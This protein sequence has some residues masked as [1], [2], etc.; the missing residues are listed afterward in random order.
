V[1]V[2]VMLQALDQLARQQNS[3]QVQLQ[4]ARGADSA[5]R[6]QQSASDDDDADTDADDDDSDESE[7]EGSCSAVN[8]PVSP[9]VSQSVHYL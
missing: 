1:C 9:S 6:A 5:R 2:F 7:A 4:P 3:S 8:P